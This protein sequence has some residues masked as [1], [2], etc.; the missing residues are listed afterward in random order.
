MYNKN[1]IMKKYAFITG[2][3]GGIGSSAVDF[4]KQHDYHCVLPLRSLEKAQAFA[5]DD[6]ITTFVSG[7]NDIDSL[8]MQLQEFK[9]QGIFFDI[10]F[11]A[12]G[13]FAWDKDFENEATAIKNLHDANFVTKE[14]VV[15]AF[16]QVYGP[17]LKDI[18]VIIISSHAAHFGL[19]HPF[20]VGE[21]GYVQSMSKVSSMANF[22]QN[23]AIFKNVFLEEPGRVGTDSAKASFTKETIGETPD[24]QQE[25]SPQDYIKEVFDKVGF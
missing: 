17:F 6:S 15:S 2:G 18:V 24:W 5:G 14:V 22:L 19:E 16:K 12:A 3:N 25:K 20:R 21:E 4:L 7:L 11:L 13:R 10:V 8:A 9:Q 23:Q 1:I